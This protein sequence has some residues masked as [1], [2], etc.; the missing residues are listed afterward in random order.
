[1]IKLVTNYQDRVKIFLITY[2]K[3]F[4]RWQKRIQK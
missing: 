1:M 2:N 3:K 4:F